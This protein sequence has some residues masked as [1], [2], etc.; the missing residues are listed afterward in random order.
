[1]N[2]NEEPSTADRLLGGLIDGMGADPVTFAPLLLRLRP[3]DFERESS[4][5]VFRAIEAVHRQGR[6]VDLVALHEHLCRVAS[7][8]RS[9]CAVD[10]AVLWEWRYQLDPIDWLA[11][12]NEH[13]GGRRVVDAPPHIEG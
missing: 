2:E 11:V 13:E 6:Q 12:W 10:L 1:M 8:R 3:E 5:M 9:W 7:D 4:R